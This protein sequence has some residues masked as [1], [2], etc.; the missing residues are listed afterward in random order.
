MLMTVEYTRCMFFIKINY[1]LQQFLNYPH[2]IKSHFRCSIKGE[3]PI[4][5]L[6]PAERLSEREQE[7]S[8]Y[9]WK[10]ECV[11]ILRWSLQRHK[12]WPRLFQVTWTFS[13]PSTKELGNLFLFGCLR[14]T[15]KKCVLYCRQKGIG[16]KV[17]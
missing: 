15:Y 4:K 1:I 11:C 10:K 14:D 7:L 3:K 2:R 12:P 6:S 8:N 16:K 9:M 13:L 5:L 17:V